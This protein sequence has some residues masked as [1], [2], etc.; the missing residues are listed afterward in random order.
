MANGPEKCRAW[1]RYVG[2]RYRD[3]DNLVWLI[4]GDRNP[5]KAR[6]DV[7]AM[8]LGIKEFD[9]RHLF[10]AHCHP[11][12]S[13]MDQFK[14]EGWLDLNT[15]YTYGIVHRMLLA[16]FNRVP[17]M[18]FLLIE[19]T[20]EGE[21]NA[22]PVQIRRQAYWAVLC[23]AAGQVMGNRPVWL[24]DPGWE[25]A[26]DS[27][28]AR[29]MSRLHALFTSRPWYD[30][31]PDQKHEVV[32]DGLGE[33]RGLDYLAAARTRDGGTVIA[34]LPTS[35]AFTVDMTKIAGKS[36]RAWW[37]NPRDGKWDPA[38][39]FPASGKRQFTPPGEGDWVLVLDD[40]S[41]SAGPATGGATRTQRSAPKRNGRGA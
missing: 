22:S 5:E 17:A 24:F 1:G 39:E 10:T 26:L 11:E 31:V 7:D 27:A 15:T 3:F 41:R 13:A 2:K 21:H 19:S 36:V 23:G 35:R 33:F 34:Y 20:Y 25:V 9:S 32:V 29:D 40:A 37:F 4:G 8:V 6:Q 16:D 14:D 30:L 28:G 12:N 18:P 38:G